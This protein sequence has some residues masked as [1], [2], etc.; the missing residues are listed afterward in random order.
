MR[1]Q[2]IEAVMHFAAFALVGES[3]AQPELYYQNNIVGTLSLMESMR[4]A[5]V[6]RIV[7]GM[8]HAD[9]LEAGDRIE[10]ARVIEPK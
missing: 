4:E 7:G 3:V 8:E 5:G 1:E 10:S 2:K 9:A 6:G